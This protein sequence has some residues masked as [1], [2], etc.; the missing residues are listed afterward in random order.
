MHAY[1][2]FPHR[3]ADHTT[4]ISW[5]HSALLAILN[6]TAA[7]M[8]NWSSCKTWYLQDVSICYEMIAF[9]QEYYEITNWKIFKHNMRRKMSLFEGKL[10][11]HTVM[12]FQYKCMWSILSICPLCVSQGCN[13]L[14]TRHCYRS[15][16]FICRDWIRKRYCQSLVLSTA[17]CEA[18]LNSI[19]IYLLD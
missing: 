7:L 12:K 3:V 2:L 15:W 9:C 13:K 18:H 5:A 14:F 1:E 8:K 10:H 6:S 17:F 16:F 4:L 19:I 11:E